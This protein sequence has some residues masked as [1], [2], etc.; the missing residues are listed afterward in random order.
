MCTSPIPIRNPYYRYTGVGAALIS[1]LYDCTSQYIDVPCGHCLQCISMRQND[2]RQRVEMES[3]DNHLFFGTLTYN[4]EFLPRLSSEFGSFAGS[5]CFCYSDVREVFTRLRASGSPP[6]KYIVVSEYGSRKHRPHYHFILSS[7]GDPSDVFEK[8]QL[9]DY[10][11]RNILSNWAYNS[12]TRKHP[13]YRPRL[14]FRFNGRFRNYDFHAIRDIDK[15]CNVAFYITK[16][17]ICKQDPFFVRNKLNFLKIFE[18]NLDLQKKYLSLSQPK[19]VT[20]SGF[21]KHTYTERLAVKSFIDKSVFLNLDYP[22]YFSPF[23]GS[24]LPLSRYLYKYDDIDVAL[25]FAK[26]RLSRTVDTDSAK[27]FSKG[28]NALWDASQRRRILNVINS[29][30]LDFF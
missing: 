24:Q 6:F 18:N 12:G 17:I 11:Y 16:Y 5:P 27:E 29:S 21:G 26:K 1:Q 7:P 25:F 2:F 15:G 30:D 20:S 22:T 23:D 9:E 28:T 3:L 8:S 4:D 10:F 13:V 14:T 19:V